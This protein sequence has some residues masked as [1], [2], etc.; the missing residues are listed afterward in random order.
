MRKNLFDFLTEQANESPDKLLYAFHDRSGNLTDSV[1][2]GSFELQ[3]NYLANLLKDMPGIEAGKPVLL[4]FTPGLAMI[5]NFFA[6]AK[7]GA[8]PVPIPPVSK[9]TGVPGLD[10]LMKVAADSGGE[11]VLFDSGQDKTVR[12]ILEGREA[13]RDVEALRKVVE[14]NWFDTST[15]TGERDHFDASPQELLFLQYTSGSTSSPRGVMVQHR[16]VIDN[17]TRPVES[18]CVTLSWLPHYHDMGLI[19]YYLFPLVFGGIAHHFS[20]MNFLRRPA[21]WFEL[22]SKL[23]VNRTSA[24]NF[25]FDYCLRP[26]RVP[27]EQLAGLDLSS[28]V[29]IM[30][31]SEPVRSESLQAFKD[32][33]SRYGLR[34]SALTVAFGL[35]ENT[36]RVTDSGRVS[37]PVSKEKLALGVVEP[38]RGKGTSSQVTTLASCG[39]PV[40]GVEI[41]IVDPDT[42]TML[43]PERTGEIWVAGT[44][45][46]D[47]YWGHPDHSK[48]HFNAQV[49][50]RPRAGGYMRTGDVGFVEDGELYVCGRIRDMVIIR[51]KNVFP[52]DV[53]RA[54]L[55]WFDQILPGRVAVFGC[56]RNGIGEDGL[57]IVVEAEQKGEKLPL[58]EIARC[59]SQAFQ[60]NVLRIAQIRRGSMPKTSSGKIA[61]YLCRSR[62]ERDEFDIIADY[63]PPQI[64]ETDTSPEAYLEMLLAR[65]AATAGEETP[66]SELGLNS[67][68]LVELATVIQTAARDAGF[69][70][71]ATSAGFHDLRLLQSATI[72]SIRSLFAGLAEGTSTGADIA[73][74]FA[75]ALAGIE[76]DEASHMRR[77]AGLCAGM[78][79]PAR[80]KGAERDGAVLVTGSTGFLGSFLIEALVRQ[81]DRPIVAL[82]RAGNPEHAANRIK[83]ALMRTGMIS[84]DRVDEALASRI[85]VVGGDIAAPRF[86]L[87]DADWQAIADDVSEVLHCG[88]L[89]DYVR[90]YADMRDANV[91]GTAEAVEFCRQ[92]RPKILN[93]ISTTFVY[94]WT[95]HRRKAET[96]RNATMEGLDFG[97]SQSK[98][99]AEQVVFN[100]ADGGLNT[101]VFRPS[102]ITASRTGYYVRGDI[103]TRLLGY[104]IRHG[105]APTARNQLS[106]LPVE[107]CANN[108]VAIS[109]DPAS[110]GGVYG[111]TANRIYT[112]E[113]VM[114][115]V[116]KIYGY[117]MEFLSLDEFIDHIN[118]NCDQHDDLMPLKPFFNN[119]REKFR[120]IEHLQ[121][122][123]PAYFEWCEKSPDMMAEPELEATVR[124]IVDFLIENLLVAKP[125]TDGTTR[126]VALA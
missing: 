27:D 104:C 40:E 107:V 49:A 34:D 47:G 66:I 9:A 79:F 91:A 126:Q 102:L 46:A 97:Y 90:P 51:G 23:R 117:P 58:E 111:L 85:S 114:R 17:C 24:P 50:D 62:L 122:E 80:T 54:V 1:T 92:G 26:D 88:A 123:N 78:E 43:P 68:D 121:Y 101:R 28:L 116:S 42:H 19:G 3:T 22:I 2:R 59:V 99:A 55:G 13:G 83:G 6:C 82:V 112:I 87:S 45:K 96:E 120:S 109:R 103:V 25:A 35:A 119:N 118:E 94:G 33:F 70:D 29:D 76:E 39:T 72:A 21:L 53:E 37:L 36:L 105:V 115:L 31:A 124:W 67:L 108:I 15:I 30:N 98:W 75:A 38:V 52:N 8:I 61:R 10:R 86:G 18:D 110:L 44:G 95:P 60:V 7:A 74:F 16:H 41:A 71:D 5:R 56:G 69:D 11:T 4:S 12:Q 100:A 106:L 89:V 48:E 77:D 65:A 73:A 57:G 14:L 125:R 113:T 81:D 93:H 32:R 20:A 63:L 84:S 64:E